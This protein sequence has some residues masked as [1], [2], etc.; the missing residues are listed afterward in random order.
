MTKKDKKIISKMFYFILRFIAIDKNKSD[1]AVD[2]YLDD[3][4]KFEKELAEWIYME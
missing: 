4:N 3:L 2:S 1:A